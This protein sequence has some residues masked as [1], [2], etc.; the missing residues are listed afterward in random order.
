MMLFSLGTQDTF[1][2]IGGQEFSAAVHAQV[3][4]VAQT[5]Q[6]LSSHHQRPQQHIPT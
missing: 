3:G 5:N 2:P 6:I 1:K 4:E